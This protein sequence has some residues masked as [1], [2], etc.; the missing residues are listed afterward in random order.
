[1]PVCYTGVYPVITKPK[2]QNGFIKK[3]GQNQNVA[4]THLFSL[5]ESYLGN[6]SG[7]LSLK[8]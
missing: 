8:S 4:E 5:V 1:M 6:G 7:S 2:Q 3:K